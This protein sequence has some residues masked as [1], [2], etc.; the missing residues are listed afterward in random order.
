MESCHRIG[1]GDHERNALFS[2]DPGAVQESHRLLGGRT[3]ISEFL[4]QF[5][6]VSLEEAIP[7][8]EDA[9]DSLLARIPVR[10]EAPL[11]ILSARRAT[12]AVDFSNGSPHFGFE[13]QTKLVQLFRETLMIGPP[14]SSP[15]ARRAT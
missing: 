1:P 2:R 7:A 4:G 15:R 6:T 3:S 13:D 12:L 10:P 9:K 14:D 5:P 11:A 8:L